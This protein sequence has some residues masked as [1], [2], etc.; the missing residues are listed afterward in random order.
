MH[1]AFATKSEPFQPCEYPICSF[2]DL[3]DSIWKGP[4]ERSYP[5]HR[6]C[7]LMRKMNAKSFLQ[8]KLI[9]NQELLEEK[10]MAEE[11]FGAEIKL[12]AVR[13]TFFCAPNKFL[14]WDKS[15]E[16]LSKHILGYA[17]IATLVVCL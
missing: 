17:V 15:E 13:L 10:A 8:E 4:K 12:D 2:F 7:T 6:L 16:H 5:L 3:I 9:L 11:N 1:N 14:N